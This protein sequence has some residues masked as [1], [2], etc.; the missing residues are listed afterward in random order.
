[1]FSHQHKSIPVKHVWQFNGVN[2]AGLTSVLA[3]LLVGGDMK[4]Y[5]T[6]RE[7]EGMIGKTIRAAQGFRDVP[8]DAE[9]VVVGI[10]RTS[11]GWKIIAAFRYSRFAFG[12]SPH[13][14]SLTRR[15]YQTITAGPP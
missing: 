2:I 13:P 7:A 1:M 15:R 6:K 5:F 8:V 4:G 11:K 10:E 9:A 3:C 14:H 12:E